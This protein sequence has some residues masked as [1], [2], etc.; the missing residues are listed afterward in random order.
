MPRWVHYNCCDGRFSFFKSSCLLL[1]SITKKESWARAELSEMWVAVKDFYSVWP[2]PLKVHFSRACAYPRGTSEMT[3]FHN[4]IVLSGPFWPLLV[5][6]NLSSLFWPEQ[7]LRLTSFRA[8]KAARKSSYVAL[9]DL[10]RLPCRSI[11]S[12]ENNKKE[13]SP[14][15]TRN[16]SCLFFSRNVVS[17]DGQFSLFWTSF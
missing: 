17:T 10:G 2:T 15:L 13:K 11:S 5:S 1:S 6:N 16:R 3:A 8:E 4:R 9:R 14:Q 12:L 7:S